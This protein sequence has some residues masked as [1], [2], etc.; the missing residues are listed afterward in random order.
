M[1]RQVIL[2]FESVGA[3]CALERSLVLMHGFNVRLELA[4]LAEVNLALFALVVLI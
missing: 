2:S 4:G 3:L 1:P